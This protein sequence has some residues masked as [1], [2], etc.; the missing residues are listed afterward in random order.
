MGTI[1]VGIILR[2]TRDREAGSTRRNG[3]LCI[4]GASVLGITRLSQIRGQI[5]FGD[6]I[7]VITGLGKGKVKGNLTVSNTVSGCVGAR[8]I[9][10]F[11]NALSLEAELAAVVIL[12]VEGLFDIEAAAAGKLLVGNGDLVP[13]VTL[14]KL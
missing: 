6:L 10:G 9:T 5:V 13:P 2:I 14:T 11:R 8:Y 12:S 7:N 3:K 4:N 1:L